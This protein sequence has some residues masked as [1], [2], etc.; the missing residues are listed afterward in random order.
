V[1]LTCRAHLSA[2]SS[3]SSRSSGS[4]GHEGNRHSFS[5]PR[6][7]PQN[8]GAFFSPRA[9]P[10]KASRNPFTASP[11]LF[12]RSNPSHLSNRGPQRRTAGASRPPPRRPT[13]PSRLRPCS[14][15]GEPPRDSLP[16][17]AP[18]FL[19]FVVSRAVLRELRRALPWPAV[20]GAPRAYHRPCFAPGWVRH[21][22]PFAPEFSFLKMKPCSTRAS[23][24][25]E[26]HAAVMA[27]P[28]R[29]PPTPAAHVPFFPLHL[30]PPVH[31]LINGLERPIPLRGFS[32]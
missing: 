13:P 6:P 32:F 19:R 8:V 14:S 15:L 5:P 21:H 29:P 11:L 4:L 20:A 27:A 31:R 18:S 12:S 24:A 17:L 16:L 30:I 22:L 25:G 7:L 10:S 3:T 9:R 26:L 23:N 28:P 2:P 1:R